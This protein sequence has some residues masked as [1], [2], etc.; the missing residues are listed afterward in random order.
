MRTSD[1]GIRNGRLWKLDTEARTASLVAQGYTFIDGVLLEDDESGREQSV[2]VTE[3]VKF[4]IVRLYFGGEKAGTDEV[5]WEALPALPDGMERDAAGRIWIG[6]IKQRSAILTWA[7]ANPWIK[8][9]LLRLPLQMLPVPTVTGAL[10]L[11]PDASR[12]LWY[13]EHPGTQVHDIASVAAGKSHVYL[14]NFSDE[15]PG[16]HRIDNPLLGK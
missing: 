3:T 13:A 10:A 6:M 8:P 1:Q 16:L 9:L 14:A 11:S 5:I 2:L 4:R 12:V 7:H 15:T